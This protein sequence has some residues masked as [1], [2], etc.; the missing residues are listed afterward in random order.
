[1]T[2]VYY[3]ETV[4]WIKIKLGIEVGLV[5]S[6]IV[7]DGDP[8]LL[9]PKGQRGT[10][11]QLSAHACCCQK[12]GWINTTWYG[13]R[14]WLWPHCVRWEPSA[15]KRGTVP[16][17]WPMSVVTKRLDGSRCHLVLGRP[18]SRRHCT[19]LIPLLQ[20]AAMPAL[21]ALY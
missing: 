17:F 10:Y 12:A 14:P 3:G 1:M 20:C 5:P 11:P 21:Q 18:R 8:A 4:G 16:Q 2:L 7:L 15:P 19:Q 13:G 6:H 9:P